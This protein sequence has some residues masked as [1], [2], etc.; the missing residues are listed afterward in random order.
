MNNTN[1]KNSN[2]SFGLLFFVFFFLIGLYPIINGNNPKFYLLLFGLLFLFLG[3]ANSQILTPLNN[4]WTKIG[5]IIG[6]LVSPIIMSLIFFVVVT[7][8]G[9]VL[10]L[11]GKDILN[12]KKKK[13]SY[14]IIRKD[15][16]TRMKNQF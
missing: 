5:L 6:K 1:K 14:W 2:R 12:L 10:K 11:L 7:P 8:I 3:L 13:S 9:I 15:K 4:L 16:N